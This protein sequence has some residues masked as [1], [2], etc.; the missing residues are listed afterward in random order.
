VA[1]GGDAFR[2]HHAV[3]VRFRDVDAMGHAH[4]SLPLVY[5]EEARAA[6]WRA[7]AGRATV[8]DIDYVLAEVTV[9]FHQRITYPD[10]LDV[11]VRVS[12][13]GGRSFEMAFEV[14]SSAGA[15]LSS[16]T[17]VQVMYDYAAG[18]SMDVPPDVRRRIEAYEGLTAAAT[19]PPKP[20][21]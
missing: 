6:Y 2:F 18:S 8:G 12:R 5:V 20:G 11:A 21:R 17:T 16:G 13:L 7:I 14:R 1:D 10:R 19:P 9:R 15:L 4:H 3:D